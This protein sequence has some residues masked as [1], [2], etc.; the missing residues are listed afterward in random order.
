[1]DKKSDVPN[2]GAQAAGAG[3]WKAKRRHERIALDAPVLVSLG[4]GKFITGRIIDI[5][6]GGLGAT[7]TSL[8]PAEQIVELQFSLPPDGAPLH[9]RSLTKYSSAVRHGFE[10]L[11]LAPPQREAIAQLVASRTKRAGPVAAAGPAAPPYKFGGQ[12]APSCV[13]PVCALPGGKHTQDC[14]C[15]ACGMYGGEHS[16]DCRCALCR[17]PGGKHAEDCRCPQCGAAG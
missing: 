13:C 17:V 6:E 3:Q 5:S 10:F 12:H 14:L 1:M 9:I 8:C 16:S 11:K 2:Y 15:E 7:L 4:A